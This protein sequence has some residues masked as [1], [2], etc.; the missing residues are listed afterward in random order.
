MKRLVD[1]A[2]SRAL[3]IWTVYDG[4]NDLKKTRYAAR[5]F[6]VDCNGE[7]WTDELLISDDL[8]EIRREMVARGL[9][10]LQRFEMDEPHIVEVWL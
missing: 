9:G 10:R 5:R 6:V 8:G 2:T 4:A 3:S 7:S 1:V